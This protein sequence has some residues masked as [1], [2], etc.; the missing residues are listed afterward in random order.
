MPRSKY[1]VGDRVGRFYSKNVALNHSKNLS[2][3]FVVRLLWVTFWISECFRLISNYNV[4]S[5]LVFLSISKSTG[6]VFVPYCSPLFAFCHR[7]FR[8]V[9]NNRLIQCSRT[10]RKTQPGSYMCDS[11]TDK[12]QLPK[13]NLWGDTV[14]SG[15]SNGHKPNPPRVWHFLE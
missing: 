12:S 11:S 9:S 2:L 7:T 14:H 10:L 4:I 8:P 1:R 13:K 15:V 6:F 5:L 3:L